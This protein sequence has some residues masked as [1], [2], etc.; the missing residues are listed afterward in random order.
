MPQ[1]R[2]IPRSDDINLQAF[3]CSALAFL[4]RQVVIS[5]RVRAGKCESAD[6]WKIRL[7]DDIIVVVVCFLI[8]TIH[9]SV[10]AITIASDIS[11]TWS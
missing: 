2:D 7:S 5:S 8:I 3:E 4:V 10:T 9:G 11:R 1:A 6:C